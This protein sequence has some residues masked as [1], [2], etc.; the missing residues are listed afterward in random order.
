MTP[1]TPGMSGSIDPRNFSPA[2]ASPLTTGAAAVSASS[3]LFVD[4]RVGNYQ[5]IVASAQ[6]GTEVYIFDET[7]DAIGQIT[8]TL[9][10]RSGIS[11]LH[12]LSHGEAGALDFAS[13]SFSLASLPSRIGELKSW[14]SALAMGADI[15]LYGC[16]VA[17]D[18]LGQAF[19]NQLAA[20]TGADVA[21]SSNL[22]GGAALGGDWTLEFK[23]GE[24]TAATLAANGYQQTLDAIRLTNF[25]SPTDP[26]DPKDFI[27]VS[28]TTF[29]TATDSIAGRE[30]WKT[31]GT[32]AGTV[33]VKDIFPGSNDLIHK[34]LTNDSNPRN[35]TNVGG[36]LFFIAT[37][38]IGGIESLWK[39]DG[40]EAGTI[41]VKDIRPGSG[42]YSNLTNVGGTLFFTA[43]DS[44][45]G[46]ELWKSDGTEAGTVL[47]KDINPK[48]GS[49][50]PDHFVNVGGTLFFSATDGIDS[51]AGIELWKSDGT[52]AGTVLVK[53]IAPGFGDSSPQ[54]LTNVDGTLFFSA[55][56]GTGG[57][58]ELWKSD[59][60][61]AGTMRVKDIN[62]GSNSS[63][64][65]NLINV[66]G[67]LF[68][69][70]TDS[71]G[72]IE[73]W[74]SDGTEAGT[75]RV[76]DINPES[77]SSNPTNLINVGG[78]LF[79]DAGKD[80][81]GYELW[82]SDGTEAGTIRVKDAIPSFGSS[83]PTS[84]I[85]FGGAVFFNAVSSTGAY[86]LWKSDGTGS[87]ASRVQGVNPD[88][89]RS[90]LRTVLRQCPPRL[91]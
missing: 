22:T 85:S 61:K 18:A 42:S 77:N 48:G 17:Q 52:E 79:F 70:A 23:T 7:R 53:D 37:D 40:T 41:P 9:L 47:V 3:L 19:V 57:N 6:S 80:L 1:H 43:F 35:L 24:I 39:S 58:N 44:T 67:T 73:L 64:P 12:I 50:W 86:E 65:T 49:S 14:G 2:H 60:T 31:D 59:G 90:I 82:K 30:L 91:R 76:K 56:D 29:F 89:T 72:G 78:T 88:S 87:V 81:F 51:T 26:S 63:N 68:F 46:I 13:G 11:A 71:I 38:R 69:S 74:K 8:D 66:G 20:A 54:N 33:R 28:G 10:G 84:V 5:A 45:A 75:V 25:D 27:T 4:T 34:N 15:L 36:S 21:A 62:P 16:N 32:E 55:F 83:N